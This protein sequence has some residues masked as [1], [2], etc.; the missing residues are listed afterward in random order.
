M[1]SIKL[2]LRRSFYVLFYFQLFPV[3]I[4]ITGTK[5][6]DTGRSN[7]NALQNNYDIQFF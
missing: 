4:F 3:R 1:N 5:T 7:S 6:I 2:M